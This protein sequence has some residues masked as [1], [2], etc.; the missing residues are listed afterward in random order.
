NRFA[1]GEF[2]ADELPESLLEALR[3]AGPWE[4][5]QEAALRQALDELPTIPGRNRDLYFALVKAGPLSES[6]RDFLL[7]GARRQLAWSQTVGRLFV[8]SNPPK[9]RW[10]GEYDAA[11]SPFW[12]I[13]EY[14]L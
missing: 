12:W 8:A 10:S 9:H 1:A 11:G 4:G 7:D 14:A 2:A 6:Q 5:R 13:Y 3:A